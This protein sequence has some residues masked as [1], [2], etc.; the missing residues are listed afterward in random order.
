MHTQRVRSAAV[1]VVVAWAALISI[2]YSKEFSS[3]SAIVTYRITG[4]IQQGTETLYI[5]DRGKK[6]RV[7]KE[8]TLTIMGNARKQSRLEIDDGE[9][10]YTIDLIAKTG[11]KSASPA[12]RADAMV[13]SMSAEQK[14]A[15]EIAGRELARGKEMKAMGKGKILGKECDIYELMGVK[16]WK[17]NGLALKTESPAMGNMVREATNLTLDTSIPE[18]KFIPPSGITIREVSGVK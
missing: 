13:N 6:T 10:H 17:W 7:E 8:T 2:A 12:K 11:E 4:S 18:D 9:F 15:M 5:S 3:K 16:T 1:S 14:K